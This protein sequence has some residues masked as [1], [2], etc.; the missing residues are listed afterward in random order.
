[1]RTGVLECYDKRNAANVEVAT[2]GLVRMNDT[3]A[4]SVV[5]NADKYFV[6]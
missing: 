2:G 1:M 4:S 5:T 6:V 3:D